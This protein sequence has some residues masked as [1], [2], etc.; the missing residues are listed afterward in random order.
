MLKLA[1]SDQTYSAD[2]LAGLLARSTPE[3]LELAERVN[4]P[5]YL[6]WDKARYMPRP[7]ELTDRE[8]WAFVT[9]QRRMSLGRSMTPI[10]DR[11]SIPFSWLRL[12]HFDRFLHECD[13]YLSDK[14]SVTH[15][16]S[17]QTN[18][19]LILSGLIEE[20]IATAQL[21]GAS[22]TRKV[23]KQML[24]EG[25]RPTTDSER[26]ILNSYN[27]MVDIEE[28]TKLTTMTG[29]RL[30]ALHTTLTKGTIKDSEVGRL[31]FEDE[32]IV[33]VEGSG[34]ITH[35]PPRTDVVARELPRLIDFA[36]DNMRE[37]VFL[38]PVIKAIMLHFWLAY[39]HPF[40]DGNGRAAR[41]L[42]YWYLLRHG[43]WTFA[44]MPMSLIIKRAP[45]QYREAFVFT[46]QDGNDLTY[47][48]DYSLKKMEQ[49]QSEFKKYRADKQSEAPAIQPE[50]VERYGM[51]T[52]QA[53]LLR[54]LHKRP[55]AY[56]TIKTHTRL[57]SVTRPTAQADLESL[58]KLGFLSSRKVG[59]FRHFLPTEKIA[60]L[61]S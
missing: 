1:G 39:L 19:Q 26:M 3:W 18:K 56:T 45:A 50:L 42:M 4:S 25:R 15:R 13:T 47:F 23:A 59:K 31:R 7:E 11:H 10:L 35:V 5:K 33:V 52:R 43:Y 40:T 30:L 61:L 36:N 24:L 17:R 44:Y 60:E 34:A 12:P 32:P 46:E 8:F 38:H 2:E 49:A 48:I 9:Y 22:T 16:R 21:E 55:D 28:E 14:S 54:Y 6:F 57:Y 37:S 58:E 53:Q 27:A 41:A 51:N 29:E 20:A